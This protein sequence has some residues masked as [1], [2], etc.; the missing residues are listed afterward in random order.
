[1]KVYKCTGC[2]MVSPITVSG[3]TLTK[4]RMC[5]R[6]GTSERIIVDVSNVPVTKAGKRAK[7]WFTQRLNRQSGFIHHIGL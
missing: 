1:M 3:K 4:D 5:F 7:W 2:A 6:C